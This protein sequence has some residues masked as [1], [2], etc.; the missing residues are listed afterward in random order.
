[1]LKANEDKNKNEKKAM[2]V[3][4]RNFKG[5]YIIILPILLELMRNMRAHET[6]KNEWDGSKGDKI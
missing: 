3:Q 5:S 1:M 4:N 6:K 2:V